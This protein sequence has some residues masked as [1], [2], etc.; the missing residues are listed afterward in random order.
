MTSKYNILYNGDLAF[1][2]GIRQLNQEYEDNYWQILPIE[3]LEIKEEEEVVVTPFRLKNS[4]SEKKE[5]STPFDISEEKAVKAVQKHSMKIGDIERNNQIDDAYLLLGKSRYYTQR[6]VPALEALTYVIKNYPEANLIDETEVWRAKTNV[7]LNNENLALEILEK[8]FEKKDLPKAILEDSHITYALAYTQLD[9]VN[10]VIDHLNEAVVVSVDPVKKARNLFILG[11]LYRKEKDLEASQKAFQELIDFRA[12]PYRYRLHAEI[13]KI[14][15]H[16]KGTDV[17]PL[18]KRLEKLIKNRDNRPYLDALYYQLG[19]LELERGNRDKGVKDLE[20]SVHTR[21]AK[22]FQKG[23]SYEAISDVYFEEANYLQAGAYL[24]SVLD[25]SKKMNTKRIRGLR[26]KRESLETVLVFEEIVIRNDSIWN[27][28]SMD[29]DMQVSYFEDHIKNM[30]EKEEALLKEAERQ[31]S[32]VAYASNLPVFT[33]NVIGAKE[34]KGSWY[35]Y[36]EQS[37]RFGE[38][39]FKR[40]WG[41]RE[42]ADN[43]RWSETTSLIE[44]DNSV[45]SKNT[46]EGSSGELPEKYQVEYYLN[47]LPKTLKEV[48]SISE[49]RTTTYY[50]LGLIYKEQFH[51]YELSAKKFE[52]LL[53]IFPEEKVLLGTYYH[54]YRIY[55]K[56][57]NSKAEHYKKV[58]LKKY[59]E[60][61]FSKIIK[62]P[63]K[64]LSSKDIGVTAESRYK[65]IY[66]IYLE[67]KYILTIYE[68]ADALTV[69]QGDPLIPK[70]E[71]LKAYALAQVK[72]KQGLKRAL[73]YIVLNYPNTKEG[74]KAKELLKKIR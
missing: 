15:N 6:F 55:Q 32:L 28:L 38:R 2:E 71:L 64:L 9:S 22:N 66:S 56:T 29:H 25:L 69:F 3:P 51:E 39:E 47:Q 18:I 60:S 5:K 62:N 45:Q 53:E 44:E 40:K 27:V 13:E 10:E 21:L 65:E 35:F 36:S 31:E 41:D 49:L 42:L 52:T 61:V 68:I 7:R 74:K 57:G 50:Q 34:K 43:W 67:R 4:K 23:L 37:L 58:V 12:A 19:L 11:Q 30:I 17:L 48:D 63:G 14:K 16:Q 24:D 73:D 1:Q 70:Y 54:L 20:R 72:G 26:R 46:S 33:D 8:L 59:P